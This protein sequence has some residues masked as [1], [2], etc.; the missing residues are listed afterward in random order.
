M[1]S[2]PYKP[3]ACSVYDV[4]EA[5]A[6]KRSIVLLE[7]LDGST[8]RNRKAKILDLFS[9]EKVEYMKA[10][11]TESNEEFVIRLDAIRL[12]TDLASNIVYSPSAC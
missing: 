9:K 7:I 11:D 12:I 10:L 1:E 3:I 5:S 8:T 6:V 4:L 2:V